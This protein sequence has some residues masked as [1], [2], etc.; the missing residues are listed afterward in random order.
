M[1]NN[2]LPLYP[3]Y[4]PPEP[5]PYEPLSNKFLEIGR[6]G[7]NDWW[8]YLLG[9]LIVFGGY[10]IGQTPLSVIGLNAALENGHSRGEI[11]QTP[12]KILDPAFTGLSPNTILLLTMLM[13]VTA[14]LALWIVVTKLHGKKFKS[15]ITSAPKVRWKRFALTGFIWMTLCFVA[16]YISMDMYPDNYTVVFNLKPFLITLLIGILFLPIQTWWEEFFFR[17]YLFQGIGSVTKTPVVPIIVTALLFAG[18]HMFNPEV[19]KYGALAMFPAYLIPGIFLAMMAALDEGLESA[20]GMHFA[21]NLFGTFAV[22]SSGSSIQ[23]NT[24]WLA[25]GMNPA[26]DNLILFVAFIIL[27]TILSF[28]NKWNFAKL[29][30]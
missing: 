15:V 14:M 20:M 4:S 10:I 27:M 16:Q 9:I 19:T 17:G 1:E 28:T 18:I 5:K 24:I 2:E 22:T 21:N 8:R 7:K 13:F 30:R 12:E 11:L 25:D 6:S 3:D 26:A 23:G 29:Y